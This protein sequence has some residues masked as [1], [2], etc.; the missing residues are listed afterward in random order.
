RKDGRRRPVL[1]TIK[2]Q[3]DDNGE[4]I[5]FLW[6][7]ED[8]T[9]RKNAEAALLASEERLRQVLAHAD[10]LVWEAKVRVT[11]QD[12]DW[13]FTVYP[14]GLYDRLFGATDGSAGLWYQFD[15]PEREEMNRRSRQAMEG[16]VAGY[17]Q[18][19]RVPHRGIVTWMRESVA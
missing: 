14:S 4:I 10:C 12:W 15:I 16:A 11:E 13:R 8:L 5:G 18:E 1:L 7:G 3:F 2:A 6:I 19:F 17:V 9:E